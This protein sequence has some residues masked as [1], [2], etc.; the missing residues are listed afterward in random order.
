[1]P[2]R[3]VDTAPL[4]FYLSEESRVGLLHTPT[5]VPLSLSLSLSILV[6]LPLTLLFSPSIP[7]LSLSLSGYSGK[8]MFL[9]YFLFP[10]GACKTRVTGCGYLS[11]LPLPSPFPICPR[12]GT[13]VTD[14]TRESPRIPERSRRNSRARRRK[15]MT[16]EG[17]GS[18]RR[19][20]R[21]TVKREGKR[22]RSRGAAITIEEEE[23]GERERRRRRRRGRERSPKGR[24]KKKR[25]R[26]ARRRLGANRSAS[27]PAA[28]QF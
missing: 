7:Y 12:K 17:K 11:S 15:G 9:R 24:K 27:S 25:K 26:G 14:R 6:S 19:E 5:R 4:T 20:G 8:S 28:P 21:K 10:S 22:I 1:M 16:K 18:S 3:G 13:S 2:E 23:K